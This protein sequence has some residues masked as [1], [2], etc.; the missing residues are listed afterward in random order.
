MRDCAKEAAAA[1]LM[2]DR[3]GKRCFVHE[4]GR[5]RVACQTA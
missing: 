3:L 2:A 4:A 1:R 5:S